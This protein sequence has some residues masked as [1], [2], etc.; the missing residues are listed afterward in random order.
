ME[1]YAD[2]VSE[3]EGRNVIWTDHGFIKYYI[4]KNT[5]YIDDIYVRPAMRHTGLGQELANGLVEMAKAKGCTQM[6]GQVVPSANGS[7][8]SMNNL[9]A[10]GMRLYA[11]AHNIVY[12]IKDI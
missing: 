11:S 2:Y 9:I 3:R 1:M 8:K 4:E 10:Y 6:V 5:L 12:F 7:D